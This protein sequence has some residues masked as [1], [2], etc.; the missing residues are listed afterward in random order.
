MGWLVAVLVAVLVLGIAAFAAPAIL[1]PVLAGLAPVLVV[2]AAIGLGGV[3][4][5][6]SQGR[7]EADAGAASGE[8]EVRGEDERVET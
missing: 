7:V 5:R 6:R 2:A 3:W 1:G 8:S 4:W